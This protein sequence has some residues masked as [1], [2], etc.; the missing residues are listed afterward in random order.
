[1]PQAIPVENIENL[2]M[3]KNDRLMYNHKDWWPM[4]NAVSSSS[5]LCLAPLG[6]LVAHT[7]VH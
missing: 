6:L 7:V 1:M 5:V 4:F 3:G 2:K